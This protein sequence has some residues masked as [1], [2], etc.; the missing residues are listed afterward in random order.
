MNVSVLRQEFYHIFKIEFDDN[1]LNLRVLIRNSKFLPSAFRIFESEVSNLSSID[2]KSLKR[3]YF[4]SS[5]AKCV[6]LL[7]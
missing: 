6:G 7:N 3:K 4:F 5:Y 2:V 1:M